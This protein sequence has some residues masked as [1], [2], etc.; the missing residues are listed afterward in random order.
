[1]MGDAINRYSINQT[2]LYCARVR[3]TIY[4]LFPASA[5]AGSINGAA[6]YLAHNYAAP[7]SGQQEVDNLVWAG[8][9]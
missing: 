5:L 1:M 3:R 6:A 2:G 9:P 8:P 4:R 7:A